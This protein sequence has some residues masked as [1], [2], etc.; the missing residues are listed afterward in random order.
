MLLVLKVSKDDKASLKTRVSKKI[1][2]T[3]ELTHIS[4]QSLFNDYISEN[5]GEEDALEIKKKL[6]VGQNPSDDITNALLAVRLATHDAKD[7][8]ICIDGYP[9]NEAQINFLRSNLVIEPTFIFMLEC[10]D[11]FVMKEQNLVDPISGKTLTI[12]Q[13]KGSNDSALIY[14]MNQIISERKE[15]LENIIDRWELTRR[16]IVKNFDDKAIS[17]DVEHLSE[18]QVIEKLNQILRKMF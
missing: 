6:E 1:A 11:N 15:S 12:D 9:E 4:V 5:P 3:F 17:I 13:I 7:L 2:E 18:N 8:G 14:R 10:S 16:A